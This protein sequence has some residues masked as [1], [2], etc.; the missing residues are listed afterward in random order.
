MRF[1]EEIER[2]GFAMIPRLLT[3]SEVLHLAAQ[4]DSCATDQD[5]LRG[6]TRD[7]LERLP[8][9]RGLAEHGAIQ[10]IVRAV[11]GGDA[12]VVRATL[13]DKTPDANWKVPWHQDVTIA[14]K[15]KHEAGGYAP[16]S[17]KAGVVH[18]QPPSAVLQRMLTVRIHIDSCEA[19]NGALRVM[20][21]S[22]R[23]GRLDQNMV[24][25]YVDEGSAFCCAANAGDALVMRPLLL[26]ASSA[27]L[28]PRHRRVLHFDYAVG[29]LAAGLQWKMRD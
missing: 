18:V 15:G 10:D 12:F 20:P 5:G 11:L 24:D 8:A 16:W 27:S 22:H 26:H 2:D 25:R 23:L 17:I 21:G 19:A 6:G 29:H 3:S 4:L 7:V 13:F 9:L 28:Y 1:S 14:V